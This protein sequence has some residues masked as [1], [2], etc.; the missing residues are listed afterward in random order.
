MIRFLVRRILEM[1][2]VLFLIATLSFFLIRLAPG[3]P[4]SGE[5]AL[6]KETLM[7]L[8]HHYGLDQPLG[9]QYVRYMGNLLHGDLGPPSATRAAP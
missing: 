1:I 4:F 9:V 3:G 2:P 5:K 7:A 8:N 6:R